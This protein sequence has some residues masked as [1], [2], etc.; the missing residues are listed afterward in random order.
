MAPRPELIVLDRDG[1][2]NRLLPNP[3]EPR[4]SGCKTA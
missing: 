1:V 2:L 3:A 4:N